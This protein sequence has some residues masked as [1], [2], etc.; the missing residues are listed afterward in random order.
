MFEGLHISFEGHSLYVKP[1]FFETYP[2]P[3]KYQNPLQQKFYCNP[4]F[5]PPH[6]PLFFSINFKVKEN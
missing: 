1:S 3:I 6:I 2:T 4:P 5:P